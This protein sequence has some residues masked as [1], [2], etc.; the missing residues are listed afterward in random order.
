MFALAVPSLSLLLFAITVGYI[1]LN[2]EIHTKR[3]LGA[4]SAQNW[5]MVISEIDKGYSVFATL[6]PMSTPLQWY[7]G[8]ANFLSNNI[9]Q[10]Y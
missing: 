5:P 8:E 3:A 1:R 9:P 2:A 7:R 6:D 4:R 10:E